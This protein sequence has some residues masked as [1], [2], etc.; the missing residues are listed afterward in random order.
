LHGPGQDEKDKGS[1]RAEK[2]EAQVQSAQKQVKEL[3]G[4]VKELQKEHDVLT[5]LNSGLIVNQKA[6]RDKAVAS[7]AAC[8]EKD[9]T[10]AVWPRSTCT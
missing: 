2:A 5:E 1:C 3:G 10:I 8:K 7:D 9:A 6:Y 4:R